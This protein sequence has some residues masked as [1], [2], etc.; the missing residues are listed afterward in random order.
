VGMHPRG[1]RP[2]SA[3]PAPAPGARTAP[4][5]APPP[6]AA[7]PS[8]SQTSGIPLYQPSPDMPLAATVKNQMMRL[9]RRSKSARAPHAPHAP[10]SGHHPH[11][12]TSPPV[13]AEPFP[14]TLGN[15]MAPQHSNRYAQHAS[16]PRSTSH[17][18][19]QRTVSGPRRSRAQVM[20]STPRGVTLSMRLSPKKCYRSGTG[21]GTVTQRVS[22]A[23]GYRPSEPRPIQAGPIRSTIA[24]QLSLIKAGGSLEPVSGM[25]TRNGC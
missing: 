11:A 24:F 5:S 17:R 14:I 16:R 12:M 8:R 10:P 1:N 15:A 6:L 4:A 19:H 23:L 2:A 21:A 18:P 9:L 7:P 25:K 13:I 3:A 20:E 22:P